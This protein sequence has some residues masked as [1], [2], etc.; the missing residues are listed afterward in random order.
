M[1]LHFYLS[2]FHFL[3]CIIFIEPRSS[4]LNPSSAKSNLLSSPSS[5]FLLLYF[6][7]Q[8]FY[9]LLILFYVK[10]SFYLPLLIMLSFS[11]VNILIMATLKFF[12]VK[13]VDWSLSYRQF[14]CCLLFS[15]CIGHTFLFL[16]HALYFFW[17]LNVFN[18]V[19]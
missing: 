19:L 5:K 8:N 1:R 18:N 11:S 15:Q 4:L 6:R 12:S 9:L 3:V 17:K 10:L 14:L 16:L 13:S 2:F 7:F